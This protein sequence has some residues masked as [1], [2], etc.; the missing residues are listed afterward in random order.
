MKDGIL[1]SRGRII[2]GMNFVETGDLEIPDLMRLGIKAH[3]PVIDRHSPLAYSIASHVHWEL[4]RHKGIET[5][6]RISQTHVNI[7]QGANLYKELGEQC[8]S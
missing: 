5:C 1:V 2:D 8:V 3:V 6:N 7:M 4:A